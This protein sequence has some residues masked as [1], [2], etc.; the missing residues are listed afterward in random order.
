MIQLVIGAGLGLAG[1]GYMVANKSANSK[2]RKRYERD[3]AEY[4][5]WKAEKQ[6]NQW[7]R[8]YR[9]EPE[10]P[11]MYSSKGAVIPIVIGAALIA[12][13]CFYS[14]DM[15][16]TVVLRNLGGSIAGHTET[17]GFHLKAPWQDVISYDVRNNLVNFYGDTEYKYEGGSAEGKK[18]TV[19]DKS[20][21]KADIDIQVN[22]SLDPSTAEYL[23]SEYGD[24]TTFTK[25]YV[26]NDLRSI[27]REVAG[28][29]DTITMLTDRSKFTRAVQDKLTEKWEKTGLTVEQV[30]VQ[31]ITYP[32]N[33]TNSYAEAQAA[34][35]AKQKA[36]NEQ[37]TAKVQ[38]ETKK[39][40][41]QGEKDAND[42]LSQSLT[43][44]VIQKQYIDALKSI[45][46]EGNLVV[47]PEGSQP[48]VG[49][50]K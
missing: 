47:V 50:A 14:Q 46:K 43:P 40:E 25:N 27:A 1:I 12:T 28:Q 20:G 33:I 11:K 42:L 45:G 23:Y 13:T 30:N 15:G 21:A 38:A 19:N 32:K 10:E 17:A 44:E 36:K 49:D 24:Q 5:Q 48:I 37:E 6:E 2:A 9:S 7:D 34:E 41:A 26:S 31:D 35:V 8:S 4:E 29:F 39:I 22:Y 16:E 18:V 3:M